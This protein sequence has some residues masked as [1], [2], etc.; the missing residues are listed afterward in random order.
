MGRPLPV[1]VLAR[2]GQD[3]DDV[4]AGYLAEAGVDVAQRFADAL[5]GAFELLARNPG[6]GALR[7]ASVLGLPGMRCWPLRPWPHL[8]FYVERQRQ[9]QVVRVLH[10]ARDIPASLA[11]PEA[12]G[13]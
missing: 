4:V 8:V 7:Y 6:L 3:I 11:E 1:V 10:G 5:A 12:E 2:A 9:L 13:G